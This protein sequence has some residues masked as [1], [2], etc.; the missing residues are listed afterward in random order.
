MSSTAEIPAASPTVDRVRALHRAWGRVMASPWATP[1]I[2]PVRNVDVDLVAGPRRCGRGGEASAS[3]P[4]G[5][6]RACGLGHQKHS[7]P[8]VVSL[9]W[10]TCSRSR[11]I[12]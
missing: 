2:G 1:V 4:L 9:I 3:A 7:F 12:S 8:T 11:V 10:V 6:P 5:D